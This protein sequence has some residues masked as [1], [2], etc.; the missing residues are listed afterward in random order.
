M[1][2]DVNLPRCITVDEHDPRGVSGSMTQRVTTLTQLLSDPNWN[3]RE[4]AA[5][6][7][8][9][10]GP[11]AL[12]A[13]PVLIGALKDESM[14]RRCAAAEALGLMALAA[15]EAVPALVESLKDKDWLVRAEAAEALSRFG[16]EARAVVPEIEAT[17]AA[18][19]SGFARKLMTR[20]LDAIRRAT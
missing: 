20:A 12:A 10:L 1:T 8:R 18:E 16:P 9:T 2:K 4:E 17:V 19:P 14:V 13:V 6:E 7:L 5:T 15:E 11:D 3:I